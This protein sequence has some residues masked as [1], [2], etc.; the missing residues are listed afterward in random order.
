MVATILLLNS[1]NVDVSDITTNLKRTY[2][3]VVVS[4]NLERAMYIVRCQKIQAV[5]ITIPPTINT[6]FCDFFSMFRQCCNIIPIIALTNATTLNLDIDAIVCPTDISN[7]L[8]TTEVFCKINTKLLPT[9]TSDIYI[10]NKNLNRTKIVACFFDHTLMIDSMHV[11]QVNSF[12]NLNNHTETDLFLI[13]YDHPKAIN[14]CVRIRLLN[15]DTPIVFMY[16]KVQPNDQQIG[17]T[18]VISKDNLRTRT[19]VFLLSLI[20]FKKIYEMYIR[21]IQDCL[22]NA[23]IDPTTQIFNRT[24]FNNYVKKWHFVERNTAILMIDVDKFKSINDKFGHAF[25]D[26]ALYHICDIIKSCIRSYDI[27]ARYGG[28]EFVVIMQKIDKIRVLDIANR[29]RYAIA[30]TN[31]DGVHFSISVGVCLAEDF[32]VSM[33]NMIETADKFMYDAKQNGGNNVQFCL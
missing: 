21:E 9:V 29:I 12:K 26:R 19:N 11:E 23:K 25:A 20:K 15:P 22:Q 6:E 17:Y 7:I 1:A 30:T 4:N 28:D 18:A 8:M 13:N 33:Q 16:S 3:N 32:N 27:V 31:L 24:Y 10:D 14:C 2:Y 5:L